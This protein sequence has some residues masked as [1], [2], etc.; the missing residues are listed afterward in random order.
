MS[1][2]QK[3]FETFA[4]QVRRVFGYANRETDTWLKA[5]MAPMETQVREHQ[6]QLRRRLESIRRIHRATDTLEDRVQELEQVENVL[7]QQL[8]RVHATIE[9]VER[10][11]DTEEGRYA[12]AA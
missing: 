7:V 12:A 6:M 11:L 10:V 3:F 4:S 2:K 9:D 8:E 1:L 5:V